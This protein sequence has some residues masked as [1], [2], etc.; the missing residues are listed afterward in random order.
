[1]VEDANA[2]AASGAEP[3]TATAT[4]DKTV[5]SAEDLKRQYKGLQKTNER[6]RQ[7]LN[8]RL[9]SEHSSQELKLLADRFDKLTTLIEP[10]LGTELRAKLV[11]INEAAASA[12]KRLNDE[13][14]A[15]RKFADTLADTG[16]DFEDPEA[17]VAKAYYES[18]NYSRATEELAKLTAAKPTNAISDAEKQSLVEEELRKRGLKV[19]ATG[20]TAGPAKGAA[21]NVN[22]VL[23]KRGATKDELMAAA[24]ALTQRKK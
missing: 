17:R 5:V 15:Q 1:M 4:D 21:V 24:F 2:P 7:E 13:S 22:E 23:S 8:R 10:A 6:L 11:Q 20:S 14:T 12:Q 16:I 9:E 18:G 19:N 3:Q